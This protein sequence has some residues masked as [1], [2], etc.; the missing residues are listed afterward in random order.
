MNKS[1]L[2]IIGAGGH[3][4]SVAEA[5]EL[6]GQFEVVGFVDDGVAM[7]ALV[8]GYPVLGGAAHLSAY[9]SMCDQVAVAIGN[10]ALRAS[11]VDRLLQVG[12]PLATVV[13]P[14][15]MV[16]PRAQLGAGS[17]VMSGAIVGTEAK[18]GVGTIVNCGAVVD[19][20]ACV[21]DFGHLGVGACMAGGTVLGTK[22]WLQAGCALGYGVNVPSGAVLSPGTALA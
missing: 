4:Q 7:G 5:A 17:A 10:N 12:M 18:L 2:L 14:K 22:A 19:H 16:S 21:E 9:A 15:A 13:H 11:L 20:H 3:G 8:M 1:K 6:N